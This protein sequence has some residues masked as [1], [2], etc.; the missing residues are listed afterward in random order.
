[1]YIRTGRRTLRR[2]LTFIRS[3]QIR[4]RGD[5][6][7]VTF[8][9]LIDQIWCICLKT[10]RQFWWFFCWKGAE[11]ADLCWTSH[12][13]RQKPTKSS[14][15]FW[16]L[17]TWSDSRPHVAEVPHVHSSCYRVK[18]NTQLISLT[19]LI[20]RLYAQIHVPTRHWT[21]YYNFGKCEPIYE[22]L[23]PFLR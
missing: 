13:R 3:T 4:H 11:N 1:M 19:E 16:K 8:I 9:D 5:G 20:L 7:F 10:P 22:I 2:T 6:I 15:V 18:S 21:F 17:W 14:D 23:S 12:E